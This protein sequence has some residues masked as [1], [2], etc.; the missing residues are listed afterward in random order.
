MNAAALAFAVLLAQTAPQYADDKGD[1]QEGYRK[2]FREGFAEGYRKANQEAE[3]RAAA[4]AAAAAEAA[5]PR[6]TGPIRVVSA[7]YGTSSESCDAM[8]FVASKV[9]GRRSGSVEVSNK[10]CGDPAFGKRKSLEVTYLCGTM[11]KQASAY[12][13]RTIYLDCNS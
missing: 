4:A 10:M 2:G 1:F 3:Q 11:A 6:P 9:N 5:K 13:H 8:H 12:E 7:V